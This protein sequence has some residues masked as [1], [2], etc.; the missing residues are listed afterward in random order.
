MEAPVSWSPDD[1]RDEKVKVLR[2]IEVVKPEDVVIGQYTAAGDKP[3]YKD[4]DG[5]PPDSRTPTYACCVLRIR[6]ARWHGVPFIIKAG[7]ALDER[8]AEVRV[9]FQSVASELFGKDPD[10]SRNE[11]VIRFQP[12]EAIYMKM[13]MKLP[14]LE[15]RSTIG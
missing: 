9:Q 8:K 3:G 4:D 15:M 6:N 2:A 5:V 1:I 11:L 10:K 13:N 12:N 7:K 14:G